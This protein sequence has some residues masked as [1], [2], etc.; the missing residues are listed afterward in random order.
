MNNAGELT[1]RQVPNPAW[2]ELAQRADI[3]AKACV[4]WI[5]RLD[6]ARNRLPDPLVEAIALDNTEKQAQAVLQQG[7][8]PAGLSHLEIELWSD[9]GVRTCR[10]E[11]DPSRPA[12]EQAKDW[13][14]QVRKKRRGLA[15]AASRRETLD[16]EIELARRWSERIAC[17]LTRGEATSK[18]EI[19]AHQ[20]E[21]DGLAALLLPRGLWPQPPRTRD[22]ESAAGPIKWVLPGGWILLAGRSGTEN[23]LLTQ[24]IALAH[25]L[26]FH[27]A[28]VPGSHV[29]LRSPD[30]KRATAPPA[31]LE[32]GAGVAAWLSRLRGQE[33]AEVHYT[34]KRHVRK[35]RK[36]PPGTVVLEHARTLR[37][38][39]V[40]PPR[41]QLPSI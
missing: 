23:D 9:A 25:D 18:A 31:L 30:G 20:G 27:A 34:E 8:K 41:D 32:I 14:A 24:R 13:I 5:R 22:Q 16:R 26:W 15:M 2:T 1:S 3:A 29:I 10:I 6:N 35:P 36:A 28:H 19:R 7:R 40:P 39:P 21:L 17:W 37:V 4:R 11:L 38:K 12:P 33:T